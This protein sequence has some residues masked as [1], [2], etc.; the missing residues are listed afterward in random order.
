MIFKIHP[1]IRGSI[2]TKIE[3]L[4]VLIPCYIKHYKIPQ[5]RLVSKYPEKPSRYESSKLRHEIA[6]SWL[7]WSFRIVYY[8]RTEKQY[9]TKQN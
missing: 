5:W 1:K 2:E 6:F 3:S 7:A 9:T 4:F 8:R